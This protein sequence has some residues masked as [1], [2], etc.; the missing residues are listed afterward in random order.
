M[1]HHFDHVDDQ[2]CSRS[3]CPQTTRRNRTKRDSASRVLIRQCF[4][5]PSRALLPS[6]CQPVRQAAWLA[7]LQPSQANPTTP[8]LCA[9]R[10]PHL[11]AHQKKK[12]ATGSSPR[13]RLAHSMAT[14]NH[15]GMGRNARGSR[16]LAEPQ[17]TEAREPNPCSPSKKCG[18]LLDRA[19]VGVCVCVSQSV[20]DSV[21]L[22]GSFSRQAHGLQGWEPIKLEA[23]TER[24]LSLTIERPTMPPARLAPPSAG[25][26]SD[27]RPSSRSPCPPFPLVYP[28]SHPR[29]SFS[30]SLF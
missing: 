17:A 21:P 13:R 15:F 5:A 16:P 30:G 12:K 3:A 1:V 14:C 20:C 24:A 4:L 10:K 29:S 22:R 18:G 23:I 11:Q 27:C 26:S 2:R 7:A 25:K 6:V 28:P 8:P 19:N 9:H